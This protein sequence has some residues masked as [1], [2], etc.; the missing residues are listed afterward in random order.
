[1]QFTVSHDESEWIHQETLH[2]PI[3]R[4]P[5]VCI[6]KNVS[7]DTASIRRGFVLMLAW[8]QISTACRCIFVP[9][10]NPSSSAASVH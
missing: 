10:P 7:Y 3:C 9:S 8:L 4:A 6:D 2:D 5:C 1:M